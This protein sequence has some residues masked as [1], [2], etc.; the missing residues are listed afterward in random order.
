MGLKKA[1]PYYQIT[2]QTHL[3]RIFQDLHK[4]LF[5]KY[6]ASGFLQEMLELADRSVC[7]E[8]GN[9]I[10]FKNCSCKDPEKQ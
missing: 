9:R 3:A 1:R 5:P 4:K 10:N 2:V 7:P 6:S 8:C